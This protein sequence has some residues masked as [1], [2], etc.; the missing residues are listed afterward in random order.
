MSR[1]GR[2]HLPALLELAAP[3]LARAHGE[4]RLAAFLPLSGPQAVLGDETW[5]GLE[6]AAE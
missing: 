1:P 2:R 6:L 4:L 5:R 3:G